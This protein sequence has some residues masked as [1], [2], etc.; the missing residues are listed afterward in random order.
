VQR[1]LY[2]GDPRHAVCSTLCHACFGPEEPVHP[3][4]TH[5]LCPSSAV[6]RPGAMLQ[7]TWST[8]LTVPPPVLG[9]SL[10]RSL[11]MI[12]AC[13][14]VDAR[15]VFDHPPSLPI[16]PKQARCFG[17]SSGLPLSMYVQ[18]LTRLSADRTTCDSSDSGCGSRLQQAGHHYGVAPPPAVLP[19]S[20]A[21]C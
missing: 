14:Q 19:S 1:P 10:T 8:A 17:M 7:V 13:S 18:Q 20:P 4:S 5:P 6:V 11:T 15:Q 9:N 3:P 21:S 16:G 2:T 12:P